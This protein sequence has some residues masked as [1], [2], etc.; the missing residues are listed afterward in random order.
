MSRLAQGCWLW[1][2]SSRRREAISTRAILFPAEWKGV[3]KDAIAQW[4]TSIT[5]METSH[6]GDISAK[7]IQLVCLVTIHANVASGSA[8]EIANVLVWKS[9]NGPLMRGQKIVAFASLG[10]LPNSPP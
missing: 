8:E 4:V 5:E 1:Q 3:A 6:I 7:T 10:F 2:Q 9:W